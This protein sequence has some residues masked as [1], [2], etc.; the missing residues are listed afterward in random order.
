MVAFMQYIGRIQFGFGALDTLVGELSL[1]KVRRP[2]VMTDAGVVAAGILERVTAALGTDLAPACYASSPREPSENAVLEALDLYREH[3]CD[4]IVAVGGGAVIDLAKGVALLATHQG[5]LAR[6]STAQGGSAGITAAVAPVVSIPT[7]AGTGS[8]IGRGAG[9]ATDDGRAKSIFLSVNLVPKVAICDPELTLSLPAAATAGSGIDA[10]GHCLE[11]YL[12]PAVNPPVDAIALDGIARILRHLELAVKE[13]GHRDARWNMMMGAIEGGMCFWKGLGA[14]HALSIP[15]DA[16]GLHHGTL[17]GM[18]LPAT[19]RF[20]RPAA[21]S[22]LAALDALA[23]EPIEAA[24]QS[25]AGRIG[26]PRELDPA[27]VPRSALPSI[28]EQAAA[29]VFNTTS[30]RR[31]SAQDYLAILNTL[32]P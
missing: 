13:P 14:A 7:T 28:A 23:G 18:L 10:L 3:R 26:L 15:L 4:G 17:I 2:L 19:L 9:I 24:L 31:G 30:A 6:Y 27:I 32:A 21:A 16:Y 25:L 8:E 12:S 5:P 11:A 20:A 29:S 1:L 22:R